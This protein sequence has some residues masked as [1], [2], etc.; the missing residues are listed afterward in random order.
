MPFIVDK[1]IRDSL[2]SS[3]KTIEDAVLFS[4]NYDIVY[5]PVNTHP[6]IQIHFVNKDT[7]F[8]PPELFTYYRNI[9][10]L[11]IKL[12]KG[13]KNLNGTYPYDVAYNISRIGHNVIFN[14][15]TADPEI[16][17]YYNDSNY[18]FIKVKQGYT[19]CNICTDG[20]VAITE[21]EGIYRAL[22]EHGIRTLKIPVGTVTLKG[23]KNGFI[24]G[25]SGNI[26]KKVLFCGHMENTDII[27]FLNKNN[28]EVL[29]LDNDV[30]TDYGSIIYFE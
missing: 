15:K 23:F 29:S 11:Y 20:D 10:P 21:D 4:Y 8:V 24:G 17:R 7:A 6:D 14:P 13:N 1:T 19:K 26:D 2:L 5:E 22:V 9:L 18:T 3:L 16:I 28:T 27:E 12:Y 25:A 30:L